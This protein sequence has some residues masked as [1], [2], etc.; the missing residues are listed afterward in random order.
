METSENTNVIWGEVGVHRQFRAT[1]VIDSVFEKFV[2]E[3]IGVSLNKVKKILSQR[4][5][6]Y[7]SSDRH[8]KF[9]RN[10]AGREVYCYILYTNKSIDIL[11]KERKKK[12]IKKT[13][14]NLLIDDKN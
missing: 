6:M 1:W 14:V 8:Y 10:I 12:K 13:Q 11:K 3:N 2:Q 4:G 5:M 9:S 7:K